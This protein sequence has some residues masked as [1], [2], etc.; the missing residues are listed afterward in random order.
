MCPDEKMKTVCPLAD[1][2]HRVTIRKHAKV[3][4]AETLESKSIKTKTILRHI[5]R[6]TEVPS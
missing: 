1:Y 3:A 6:H 4:Q 5:L 2:R